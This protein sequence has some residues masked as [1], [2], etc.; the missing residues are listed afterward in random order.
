MN[1][2]AICIFKERHLA[3]PFISCSCSLWKTPRSLNFEPEPHLQ[4]EDYAS[5]VRSKHKISSFCRTLTTS[6]TCRSTSVENTQQRKKVSSAL[7]NLSSIR[8]AASCAREICILTWR[9]SLAGF[10]SFIKKGLHFAF[11]CRFAIRHISIV[12]LQNP[13]AR[14]THPAKHGQSFH[15]GDAKI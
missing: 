8:T 7:P 12:H 9:G 2:C 3:C 1:R 13:V 14:N 11:S 6:S 15:Q 5:S 4:H 10:L